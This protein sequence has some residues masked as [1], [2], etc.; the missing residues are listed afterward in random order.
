[1]PSVLVISVVRKNIESKENVKCRI[2]YKG[3]EV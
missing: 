1:M 3:G 2:N